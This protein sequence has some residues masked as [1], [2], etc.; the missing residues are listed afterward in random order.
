MH[1]SQIVIHI[2]STSLTFVASCNPCPFEVIQIYPVIRNTVNP[3]QPASI[4]LLTSTT[5]DLKVDNI[6]RCI[7]AGA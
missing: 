7:F 1:F 4:A 2:L 6:F 5:D 3:G